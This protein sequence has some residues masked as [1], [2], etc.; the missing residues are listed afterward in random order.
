LSYI[1]KETKLDNGLR[2]CGESSDAAVTAGMGFFVKTGARDETAKL[3]GVSH[4]LEHMMFKGTETLS[5]EEVDLAFDNIGAEHNAFTS[6]EMTAYWGAGLPEVLGD[7][8]TTLADILRPSLRQTDF[9]NEKKVIIEEIAMYDDQPFWVLYESAMEQYYGKSPLGHRVLG[10]P[11]TINAMQR[12]ELAG[13]F[14][15]RYSAD[16]TIVVLAGKYDFDVMV[17]QIESLCGHWQRTNATRDYSEVVRHGGTFEKH[18]PELQQHY[19]L[20]M[21]PSVSYQDKHRHAASALAA[22]L[23]GG[24]GSRLHWALVDTGL[25]EASAASVDAN[26]K[27]GE[28]LTYAVCDPANSEEVAEIMRREMVSIAGSLTDVDLAKV[29]A[30]AATGA[31]VSSERPAGRMQ[32]LGSMLTTSGEYVSLEDELAS[33]ESLTI[34]DL[35]DVAE[36]YPWVP[37][38][39]ASTKHA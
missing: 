13:Y 24:D 35:Q 38:L 3:M 28:Q 2:I 12:D 8:H 26:D 33:I 32:R 23:G 4:F 39:E 11:E 17:E 14:T 21:M 20:M 30:K 29:K 27:Y 10:T 18:I 31:A 15:D 9:D 1:Y 25:A 37:L 7:I 16:N 34:K 19:H 6:G 36:A 22:I 5:A